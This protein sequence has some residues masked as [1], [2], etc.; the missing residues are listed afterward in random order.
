M[1][2]L[3][4]TGTKDRRLRKQHGARCRTVLA[5]EP[6]EDVLEPASADLCVGL[7]PETL[8]HHVLRDRSGVRYRQD[9]QQRGGHVV[10]AAGYAPDA[11]DFA[12]PIRRMIGYALITNEE[13]EVVKEREE[14]E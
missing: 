7:G 10:A 14:A 5:P 2:D 12:E 1:Y 6:A 11:T 3:C 13:R 9:L 4:P 8:N